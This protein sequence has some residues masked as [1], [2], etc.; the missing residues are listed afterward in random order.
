MCKGGGRRRGGEG[1]GGG[2]RREEGGGGEGGGGKE[3]GGKEEGGGA[4][5]FYHVLC[6]MLV[7]SYLNCADSI[8]ILQAG[9]PHVT[10]ILHTYISGF[11]T[12]HIRM[13]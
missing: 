9:G 3:E 7:L 4:F 13:M 8:P 11:N 12:Q 1:G 2:R 6:I 5:H 10:E